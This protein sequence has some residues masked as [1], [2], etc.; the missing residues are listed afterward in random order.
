MVTNEAVYIGNIN[1]RE[2]RVMKFVLVVVGAIVL[3]GIGVVVYALLVDA[4]ET[5]I[6]V[7]ISDDN[8]PR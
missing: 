4:P 8:F 6:E 1:K 5:E 7:V 2:Q 3:G